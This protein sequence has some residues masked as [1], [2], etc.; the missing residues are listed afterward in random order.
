M[1]EC[2]YLIAYSLTAGGPTQR[3]MRTTPFG[4]RPMFGPGGPMGGRGAPGPGMMSGQRP[5]FRR[6][7]RDGVVSCRLLN[8]RPQRACRAYESQCPTCPGSG[9]IFT[10]GMYVLHVYKVSSSHAKSSLLLTF[11]EPLHNPC[12]FRVTNCSIS[13]WKRIYICMY[14]QSAAMNQ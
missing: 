9:S 5:V 12:H 14:D 8:A 7:K 1:Y 6:W 10:Q 2:I 4:E 3:Q 11:G 13:D